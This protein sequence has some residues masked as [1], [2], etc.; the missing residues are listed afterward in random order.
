MK[1]LY[2][3]AVAFGFMAASCGSPSGSD[4]K[5]NSKEENKKE[6]TDK[7]ADKKAEKKEEKAE[8]P[9]LPAVPEGAKVFFANLED[10]AEVKS[11]VAVEFG[12]EG[13]EVEPA[14]EVAEGTGHHHIVIDGKFIE[15]GGTVPADDTHIHYGGGQVND[16]LDLEPGEHTLTLQFADGLH[17][18]YGKQMSNTITVKV[19]E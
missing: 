11:P 9:E 14:G 17:R 10:G 19:A 13:M 18:S 5:E 3:A 8:A 6:Q 15:M 7:K 16:T 4:H 1:K 2:I 12:V